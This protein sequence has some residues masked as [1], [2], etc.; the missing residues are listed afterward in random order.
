MLGNLSNQKSAI[1]KKH[2]RLWGPEGWV[3]VWV[4]FLA[5]FA[6]SALF[7]LSRL[8]SAGGLPSP[9][10]G[11][12]VLILLPMGLFAAGLMGLLMKWQREGAEVPDAQ[13]ASESLPNRVYSW[14]WAMDKDTW[15][16]EARGALRMG[17]PIFDAPQPTQAMLAQVSPRDRRKFESAIKAALNG[18]GRI[19][20][21]FRVEMPNGATRFFIARGE[22]SKGLLQR[23]R[24]M[25]GAIQEVSNQHWIT[26]SLLR[27]DSRHKLLL[28]SMS[29]GIMELSPDGICLNLNRA[30]L[31][32]LGYMD[33]NDVI[34]HDFHPL[35]R[36]STPK[37]FPLSK[38]KCPIQQGMQKG[39]E[40]HYQSEMLFRADGSGFWVDLGCQ[41]I[42][43]DGVISGFVLTFSDKSTQRAAEQQIRQQAHI[44]DQI[45]EGVIA[46]GND[47]RIII[48]NKGAELM[49]G[50]TADEMLGQTIEKIW[51]SQGGDF[52]EERRKIVLEPLQKKGA[53]D[54][55]ADRLHKNGSIIKTKLSLSLMHNQDGEPI[56]YVGTSVDLTEILKTQE[57]LV[58]SKALLESMMDVIPFWVTMK[59]HEMRYQMVNRNILE[60]NG[61]KREE[62]LGKRTSELPFP[63]EEL[64][65]IEKMDR[66]VLE[67]GQI[68]VRDNIFQKMADGSDRLFRHIKVPVKDSA[69]SVRNIVSISEDITEIRSYEK[70]LIEQQR[71][72]KS[73]IDIMPV[74]VFMK[75]TEARY[76]L[77]NK[78]LGDM[79]GIPHTEMLGRTYREL[80]LGGESQIRDAEDEDR[81]V[82][83]MAPDLP[84]MHASRMSSR[85]WR[86][87]LKK[88][89]LDDEGAVLGLV[90]VS[91]NIN[92]IVETREAL[93]R[94][95]A[96]L[97]M[98]QELSK[99]GIW[100]WDLASGKVEWTREIDQIFGCQG[101]SAG[102]EL[103]TLLAF[104]EKDER[105]G[106]E[107]VIREAVRNKAGFDIAHKIRQPRGA[108]RNVRE[109][110]RV[111]LDSKGAPVRV[112]GVMEDITDYIKSQNVLRLQ[113]EKLMQ[114]HEEMEALLF[115]ASHGLQ[116]PLRKLMIQTDYLLKVAEI[117]HNAA[118][119]KYLSLVEA[120]SKRMRDMI[121]GLVEYTS[122]TRK[123]F[124]QR[125][126]NLGEW[127]GTWVK[128]QS[129]LL[130]EQEVSVQ[131]GKLP[132]VHADQ[133]MLGKLFQQLLDNSIRFKNGK[134]RCDIKISHISKGHADKYMALFGN[135]DRF[136]THWVVFE[137]N[138]EGFDQKYSNRVFN[139]FER[140]KT[141]S[142]G[143]GV[144]IGLALCKKVMERHGGQIAAVG[145]PGKGAEIH[146]LFPAPPQNA[147]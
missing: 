51:P 122:A 4:C 6:L 96:T 76:V 35:A 75:D 143:S 97:Q 48:W 37:G 146:M 95:R 135:I 42:R 121:N 13:A 79:H 77:V 138:G 60:D 107:K 57:E 141:D 3:G 61:F 83:N 33:F 29:E 94:H 40:A 128:W 137:D 134:K 87:I 106:A 112:L 52:A 136:K 123:D 65:Q 142:N 11:T 10:V 46:L 81:A 34:G 89:L 53:L 108:L 30:A 22:L 44:L 78:T 140:L 54:L 147:E 125:P 12:S 14:T 43:E 88:P 98:A 111:L 70:K 104:I 64:E 67:S 28:D 117:Q 63:P 100:D 16:L 50:Y 145:K 85:G 86:R 5:V 109:K 120:N 71:L 32:M 19:H 110:G 118:S 9:G 91:I 69:G 101:E 116:E 2:I 7:L 132:V 92:E 84:A 114:G 23:G 18:L 127:L 20:L 119:R 133:D 68:M 25:E 93:E 58:A 115:A 124:N 66:E 82:L 56:G 55:F 41:P 17:L 73:I 80:Q 26:E 130:K 90:G 99:I 49:F 139:V 72:L 38:N 129:E 144:G 131:V 105:K 113:A 24:V 1:S 74:G 15:M 31:N 103:S 126:C 36:H 62:F 8:Q 39:R 47:Q 21:D 59:D 102:R 27:Q 45:K